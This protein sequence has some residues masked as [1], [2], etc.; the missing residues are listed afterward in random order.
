M[1]K[2][3]FFRFELKARTDFINVFLDTSC[4]CLTTCLVTGTCIARD[5]SSLYSS[6]FKPYFFTMFFPQLT[7]QHYFSIC[8]TNSSLT[9]ITAE[10]FTSFKHLKPLV[11]LNGNAMV[12][13][14]LHFTLKEQHFSG[15]NFFGKFMH[16][17]RVYLASQSASEKHNQEKKP[18]NLCAPREFL[19]QCVC[20][21]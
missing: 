17:I 4:K 3:K 6:I 11:R 2:W 16:V 7:S 10:T 15:T 21:V 14:A 20:H 9:K 19:R 13:L 18:T 5:Y 8:L 12:Y 1:Q